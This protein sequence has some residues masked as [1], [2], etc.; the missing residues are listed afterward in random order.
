MTQ[1][2]A[3]KKIMSLYYLFIATLA[4]SMVPSAAFAMLALFM[5]TALMILAYVFRTE[6]DED[7]L[8]HNHATYI[9]RTIWITSLFA[10]MTMIAASAYMIPQIDYSQMDACVKNVTTQLDTENPDFQAAD[11][12]MQPC[13]DDFITANKMV[14]I[15]AMIIAGGPLLAYMIF[16]LIKGMGRARH[17]HKVVNLKNWF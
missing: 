3:H 17:G 4:A 6:V 13:M 12:L 11:A 8:M 16:R 10:A 5:I 1:D 2:P 15:F 14:F 9:I 7:S